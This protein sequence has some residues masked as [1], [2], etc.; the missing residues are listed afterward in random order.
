M[1]NPVKETKKA[2][3]EKSDAILLDAASKILSERNTI[4][5]SLSEIAQTSGLNSALISYH[6]G[7]KDGL[8]LALLRRDAE[9]ALAQLKQLV[10]MPLSPDQKIRLHIAGVINTYAKSPYLNRLIHF[11][12]ENTNT[13]LAQEVSDFFIK[14]LIAAQSSII[15]EGVAAGV[16]RPLDPM[17]FYFTFVG[18]CDI[19][20]YG[21]PS[22]E[23]DA[24]QINGLT[25]ELRS[26]YTDFV[27]DAALRL[28]KKD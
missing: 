3:R 25:P 2:K 11:L 9:A 7:N 16:F 6:F 24:F 14:P 12:L 5:I 13:Q 19:I 20:F 15:G 23:N 28:L 22:L 26:R 4:D 21:R 1:R 8:L 17:F 27:V 10:A 18:A